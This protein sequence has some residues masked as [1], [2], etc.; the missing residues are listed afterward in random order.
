MSSRETKKS[1]G[2][3]SYKRVYD[4]AVFGLP[5]ARGILAPADAKC[6]DA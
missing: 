2:Q 1:E 4:L 3:I 6:N 5:R